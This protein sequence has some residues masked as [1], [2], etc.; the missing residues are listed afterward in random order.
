MGTDRSFPALEELKRQTEGLDLFI[1]AAPPFVAKVVSW[2]IEVEYIDR[3]EEILDERDE[4]RQRFVEGRQRIEATYGSVVMQALRKRSDGKQPRFDLERSK[5]ELT[6]AKK[7]IDELDDDLIPHIS[8]GRNYGNYP[9]F[10]PISTMR[11]NTYGTS[12]RSITTGKRSS[13]R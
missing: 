12:G 4:H 11:M 7:A 10:D 3:K 13:P 1:E 8:P 9:L 2:L 5:R 6:D